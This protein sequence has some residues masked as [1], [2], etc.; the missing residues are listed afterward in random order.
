MKVYYNVLYTLIEAMLLV[1]NSNI[2]VNR[3]Y[4]DNILLCLESSAKSKCI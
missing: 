4:S 2:L 3:S 1:Q